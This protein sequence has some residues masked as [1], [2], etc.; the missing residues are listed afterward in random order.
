M[1][2]AAAAEARSRC[3]AT[4]GIASW[5]GYHWEGRK[6]AS[7][8]RFHALAE[9]AASLTLPLGSWVRVTNLANGRSDVVEITDRGP[10]VRGRIVDL[11]LGT[12]MR[13]DMV[14]RGLARV[15]IEPCASPKLRKCIRR[16]RT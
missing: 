11:S 1:I 16:W 2:P 7:G 12:A 10:Y 14:E 15:R 4:I 13:L 6:T 8:E 3:A 5:Y 9:T